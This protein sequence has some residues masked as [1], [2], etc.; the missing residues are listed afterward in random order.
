[1]G[2]QSCPA[3]ATDT[4]PTSSGRP[5]GQAS[6]KRDCQ[7]VMGCKTD[8]HTLQPPCLSDLSK[9]IRFIHNVIPL[10]PT[11]T[12]NFIFPTSHFTPE[13]SQRNSTDMWN[14]CRHWCTRGQSNT[15][16]QLK[17]ACQKASSWGKSEHN[18]KDKALKE[19]QP[20]C[21]FSTPNRF[22]QLNVW[23]QTLLPSNW[24]TLKLI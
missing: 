17:A 11:L 21:W 16:H 14:R 4:F 3:R 13:S 22:T 12:R 15:T 2:W 19:I 24:F 9:H 7:A 18:G 5:E 10:V 20:F 8:M 6:S 1:M 23:P